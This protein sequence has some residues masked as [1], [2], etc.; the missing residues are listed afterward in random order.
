MR[1]DSGEILRYT[2]VLAGDRI[3]TITRPPYR[4]RGWQAQTTT[5]P[6]CPHSGPGRYAAT[7]QV[8][9]VDLLLELGIT[10]TDR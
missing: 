1:S 2:V 7:R 5:G 3:G 6:S 9:V 10:S 4:N 8:A